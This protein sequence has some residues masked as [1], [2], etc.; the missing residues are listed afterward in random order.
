MPGQTIQSIIVHRA[1]TLTTELK[2]PEEMK[3]IIGRALGVKVHHDEIRALDV[4]FHDNLRF[5][6]SELETRIKHKLGLG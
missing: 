6:R 1:G 5:F 2:L 4:Q 3:G